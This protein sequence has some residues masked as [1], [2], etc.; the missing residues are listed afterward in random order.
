MGNVNE[1]RISDISTQGIQGTTYS[2]HREY[3]KRLRSLQINFKKLQFGPMRSLKCQ[4]HKVR[5][6][7]GDSN[8]PAPSRN[9][10]AL[11]NYKI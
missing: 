3:D 8:K 10:P 11:Y 2:D 6:K 4:E 7:W 1:M 9:K 5:A